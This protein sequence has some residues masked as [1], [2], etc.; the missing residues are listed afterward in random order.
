MAQ[1]F[2][3]LTA[4]IG[5][6]V[7][8]ILSTDLALLRGYSRA[9]ARAIASFTVLL[10]EGYASGSISDE[11]MAQEMEELE[12][13]VVRFV[14]NIQA[15]ATTTIERLLRGIGDLLMAALRQVT[16]L[17]ALR[18]APATGMVWGVGPG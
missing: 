13:M 6:A 2:D 8:T 18:L 15:L 11:Q 12:R 10:G 9:K 1:D 4:G 5:A 17:P 14:R 3:Q 7:S 16:G